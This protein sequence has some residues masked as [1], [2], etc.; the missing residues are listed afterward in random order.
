[1]KPTMTFLT[2]PICTTPLPLRE[3]SE[4]FG[5]DGRAQGAARAR[6]R[7]GIP[8]LLPDGGG[9]DPAASWS[10]PGVP[11]DQAET[12]G[13]QAFRGLLRNVLDAERCLEAVPAPF[14][15]SAERKDGDSPQR[16]LDPEP[17][18]LLRGAAQQR[19]QS[20]R[21]DR[22]PETRHSAACAGQDHAS[23]T[24]QPTMTCLVHL[25]ILSRGLHRTKK[26]SRRATFLRTTPPGKRCACD[27]S[28]EAAR[29]CGIHHRFG[30]Q[31]REAR[32]RVW[33]KAQTT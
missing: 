29:A 2:S 31:P 22:K 1:M 13:Q 19:K 4:R 10:P 20:H 16:V 15:R 14:I 24:P 25:L 7:G 26:S 11:W 21:H 9:G 27:E 12:R 3:R 6:P 8:L 23:A 18:R 33:R 32:R 28:A 17:S 30:A 5:G